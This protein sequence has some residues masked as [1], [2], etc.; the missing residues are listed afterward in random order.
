MVK[1]R[2]GEPAQEPNYGADVSYLEARKPAVQ[3]KKL[4]LKH[5]DDT[6]YG[7]LRVTVDKEHLTIGFHQVS[8][9]SVTQSRVDLVTVDLAKHQVVAN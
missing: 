6:T 9:S 7:Y 5:Y 2:R 1:G 3:A 8:K 4:I